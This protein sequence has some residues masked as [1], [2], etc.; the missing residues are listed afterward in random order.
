[1]VYDL[2]ELGVGLVGDGTSGDGAIGDGSVWL[3]LVTVGDR[4]PGEH[5]FLL[6]LATAKVARVIL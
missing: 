4:S 1:M 2:G 3:L 6:T 5:V